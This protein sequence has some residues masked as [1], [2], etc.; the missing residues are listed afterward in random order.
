MT[1]ETRVRPLE[2]SDL[3]G[4]RSVLDTTG[5]F[6]PEMLDEMISDYLHDPASLQI[7]LGL[8][9]G[10]AILGFAYC[11]PERMTEGAWNL[12][13]IAV[14][15]LHQSQGHGASLVEAVENQV[16]AAGAR[17]LLVETSGLPEYARTRAF[18]ERIGYVQEARIRDFYQDGEDKVVF[19]K[20]LT[21]KA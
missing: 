13:A 15:P 5:L 7:W 19:W 18:Y 9:A 8:H 17:I 10:P 14:D 4:V 12:L 16:L 21:A 3:A 11:E 1:R 20:R 6:P 2:R